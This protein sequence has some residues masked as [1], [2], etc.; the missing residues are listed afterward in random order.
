MLIETS[1][2]KKERK[3][4][5]KKKKAWPIR[6]PNNKSRNLTLKTDKNCQAGSTI[7]SKKQQVSQ[8]YNWAWAHHVFPKPHVRSKVRFSSAHSIMM[9]RESVG[10]GYFHGRV[11]KERLRLRTK[12]TLKPLAVQK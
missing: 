8:N 6:K 3:E 11:F 12:E 7:R 5:K 2:A 4:K 9:E 10:R 1:T